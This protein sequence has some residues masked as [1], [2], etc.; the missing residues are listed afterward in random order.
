MPKDYDNRWA[1]RMQD[2]LGVNVGPPTV[3]MPAVGMMVQHASQ[4]RGGQKTHDVPKEVLLSADV[5]VRRLAQEIGKD[6]FVQVHRHDNRNRWWGF[7][8]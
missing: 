6:S 8:K 1:R 5:T 4:Q 3:S 7:R 2:K